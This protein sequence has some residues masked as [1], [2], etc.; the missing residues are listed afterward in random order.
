MPTQFDEYEKHAQQLEQVAET[1]DKKGAEYAALERAGWALAFVTMRH[2]REF[3]NFLDEQRRG[4][5][6]PQ[7]LAHLNKLGL[8]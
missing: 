1:L 7:E 4:K 8:K 2:H 5:L 3:Q 6:S